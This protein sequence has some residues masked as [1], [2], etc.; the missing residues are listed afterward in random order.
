MKTN[1]EILDN[2]GKIVVNKILD[3]YYKGIYKIVNEGYKN[4]TMLH[5]NDMFNKLNDNEKH[6][7]SD[8]FKE[9]LNSAFFD[10]LNIFEEN[11]EFKLIYEEDGKQIN[12]VEISEMLKA[13]LIIENGWIDRFSKEKDI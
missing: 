13:E 10:M 7:L 9:N 5:Y 12:L 8:F 2:F 11:E 6:L 4:P 1:Q 3:R